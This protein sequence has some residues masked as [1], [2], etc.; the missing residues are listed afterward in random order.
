M[1]SQRCCAM[2]LTATGKPIP[3][4]AADQLDASS[5]RRGRPAR[6]SVLK[7]LSAAEYKEAVRSAFDPKADLSSAKR[8]PA[9]E[10]MVLSF[11]NIVSALSIESGHDKC[12]SAKILQAINRVQD[13]RKTGATSSSSHLG[14]RLYQT[15]GIFTGSLTLTMKAR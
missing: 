4:Q 9:S 11:P 13:C 10:C 2:Y 8:Q 14:Q 5:R 7:A 1:R 12:W 3:R 15:F 6:P